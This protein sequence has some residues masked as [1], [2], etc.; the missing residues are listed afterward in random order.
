ML[1]LK[2]LTSILIFIAGGAKLL[3]AKPLA[4]QF[5]EFGLPR[6]I[7]TLV[8]ALEIAIAVA[9]QIKPLTFTAASGLVLLM[10]GAITNH[11][12]IRHP[13]DKSAPAVVVLIL[14]IIIAIGSW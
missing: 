2:A 12:K 8:G 7:M 10:A 6:Y 3:G 9:I 1:I 5:Q 4:D 13:L 11:V 14:A